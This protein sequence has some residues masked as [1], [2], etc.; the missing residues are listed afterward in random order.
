MTRVRLAVT[1]ALIFAS[2]QAAA[3][4][5]LKVD[6]DAWF[7]VPTRAI[8]PIVALVVPDEMV[9][10]LVDFELY[11]LALAFALAFLVSRQVSKRSKR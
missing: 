3:W 2:L 4:W 7:T 11:S 5:S 9:R 8:D 1:A 10:Y 6:L